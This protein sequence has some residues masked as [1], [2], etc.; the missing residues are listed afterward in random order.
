MK[1]EEL[2]IGNLLQD[3]DGEILEVYSISF[4]SVKVKKLGEIDLNKVMPIPVIEE[5][6]ERFGFEGTEFMIGKGNFIFHKW[7]KT[8]TWFGVMLLNSLWDEVHKF[9]NLHFALTGEELELK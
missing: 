3:T 6:L 9:Q 2:R 4:I 1:A 8:L 7:N 5:W